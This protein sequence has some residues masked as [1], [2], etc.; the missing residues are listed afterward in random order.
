MRRT[1]VKVILLG[2]AVLGSRDLLWREF[3][4]WKYATI[5]LGDALIK[6]IRPSAGND[7]GGVLYEVVNERS[8]PRKCEPPPTC[9]TLGNA[10]SLAIRLKM[11]AH[12]DCEPGVG[13]DTRPEVPV[14]NM[15]FNVVQ[16]QMPVILVNFERRIELLAAFLNHVILCTAY[17]VPCLGDSNACAVTKQ[18]L[19]D[20]SQAVRHSRVRVPVRC[21]GPT[22]TV[23]PDMS[24]FKPTAGAVRHRVPD[25]RM[26]AD[27]HDQNRV[28]GPFWALNLGNLRLIGCV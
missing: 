1:S 25:T 3:G 20:S 10:Y 6:E 5:K 14:S 8:S 27:V 15:K 28:P 16:I 22:G 18:A 19:Y 9:H 2:S 12:E 26:M 24:I 4:S 11:P 21:R 7:S 13:V 23:P 17:N